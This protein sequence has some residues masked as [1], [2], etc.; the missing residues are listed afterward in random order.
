MTMDTTVMVY[1]TTREPGN[2]REPPMTWS[3]ENDADGYMLPRLRR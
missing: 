2:G 3:W 1:G